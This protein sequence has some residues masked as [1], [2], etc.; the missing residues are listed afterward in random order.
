MKTKG[1]R[2]R[3]AFP[4]VIATLMILIVIGLV[5]WLGYIIYQGIETVTAEADK[6][7]AL[8]MTEDTVE[9]KTYST[10]EFAVVEKTMKSYMLQYSETLKEATT[11]LADNT[12]S[13]MLLADNIQAD[14]PAFSNSRTYIEDKRKRCEQLFA[15]IEER[16]T[17]DRILQA[18]TDAGIGDSFTDK[19][20]AKL[21]RHLMLDIVKPSCMYS[22]T[23]CNNVKQ[24]MLNQLDEK[25]KM[26]DF[27]SMNQEYWKLEDGKLIFENAE[28]TQQY[29]TLTQET[30][31]GGTQKQG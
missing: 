21:Y 1:K 13:D 16:M 24:E 20:Y 25:V 31:G 6:I 12:F 18:L 30:T 15:E 11:L 29:N 14:G 7:A 19:L 28:L 26:L 23:S 4:K 3:S 22:L 2:K 9:E 10:G 27:L 5:I 17:E 8:N